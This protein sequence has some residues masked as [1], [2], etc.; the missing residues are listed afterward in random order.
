[1]LDKVK[2][3]RTIVYEEIVDVADYDVVGELGENPSDQDILDFIKEVDDD[4]FDGT[5]PDSAKVTSTVEA[6]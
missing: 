5:T 3:K 6:S 2:I 4:S 1:M